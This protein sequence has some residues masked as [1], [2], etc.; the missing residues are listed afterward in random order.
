[1]ICNTPVHQVCNYAASS[2]YCTPP[3]IEQIENGVIPLDSLPADWWNWMWNDTNKAVNE[4][5][6]GFSALINEL[7]TVL[8]GAGIVA[9]CNCVNQVYRA[10]DKIR[11]TLATAQT[12][13]AVKS[14]SCKGD[15]TVNADGTMT[16]NGLGNVANISFGNVNSVVSGLNCL[17]TYTCDCFNTINGNVQALQ[18]GK[19]PN[20]HAST[21]A[22]YG[23][24]NAGCYG[25]VRLSDTYDEALEDQSG[26]AASQK[27]INDMYNQ[28]VD[29]MAPLSNA[30]PKDI[31]ITSAGT[32]TCSARADH[33]HGDPRLMTLE[34]AF[35]VVEAPIFCEYNSYNSNHSGCTTFARSVSYKLRNKCPFPIRA[36]HVNI[37]HN[38]LFASTCPGLPSTLFPYAGCG[39]CCAIAT[40]I[41]VA[42]GIQTAN[43][44]G[45]Y[46]LSDIFMTNTPLSTFPYVRTTC[47][48]MSVVMLLPSQNKCAPYWYTRSSSGTPFTPLDSYNVGYSF[49]DSPREQLMGSYVDVAKK[50]AGE[51]SAA[52][53]TR[54]GMLG[55]G[56]C[57][58]TNEC[59]YL[60]A[61]AAGDHRG[62]CTCRYSTSSYW[63][64]VS[65]GAVS[66]GEL[67]CNCDVWWDRIKGYQL[68]VPYASNY[69]PKHNYYQ[70]L[71]DGG[72]GTLVPDDGGGSSSRS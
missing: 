56:T 64:M 63:G 47:T 26:V 45:V 3:D 7:E 57:I 50:F 70:V 20:N 49:T 69:D 6:A 24:G 66:L 13:G 55:T 5:R 4:A 42:A 59:F 48:S 21:E 38:I 36:S 19:A 23:L 60:T 68:M 40:G 33:V 27:A 17:Y 41:N 58:S 46:A 53:L 44:D 67:I 14:S 15:V 10:I 2:Q 52:P 71:S 72:G 32:S 11:Q 16:A 1:M 35:E 8:D 43:R 34:E 61:F 37:P 65:T 22:I 54:L 30:S 51:S 29:G 25:H 31:G 18:N 62:G 28:F 39:A 12:A 9:D